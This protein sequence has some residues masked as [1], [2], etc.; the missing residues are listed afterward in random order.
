MNQHALVLAANSA[1]TVSYWSQGKR[2]VRYF[3]G[4]NKLFQLSNDHPVGLMIF[5]TATLHEVPWELV[6]K[7]FREQL[8]GASSDK[9]AGYTQKFCDFVKGHTG[10]FPAEVRRE[11]L[12]SYAMLAAWMH[13]NTW[14]KS[15]ELTGTPPEQK[16]AA[17]RQQA[18]NL[19]DQSRTWTA[20]EP[21]TP[22]DI[23]GAVAAHRDEVKT[24]IAAKP[25]EVALTEADLAAHPDL[26]EMMAEIALRSVL[27]KYDQYLNSTGIVIGGYGD[28]EFF[29]SFEVLECYGFLDQHFVTKRSDKSRSVA[30]DVPAAIEPFATTSMINTFRMGIGQDVFAS[31]LAATERT[32]ADF[33]AELIALV[34]PG[35]NVPDLTE[36]IARFVQSH[37][38]DWFGQTWDDHYHPLARV[39]SS[40]PVTDM[41]ALAKS[42]IEL[43]SLKERVTRPTE[44]VGGPIDVAVISKHDGFVWIERK[45]YFRADL[46][47]RFFHRQHSH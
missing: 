35:T 36:R 29:P 19:L 2:E 9:L 32:L 23:E 43:Q 30:R 22:E 24:R 38:N 42:L 46:N 18:Q 39:I 20:T 37:Q 21:L 26:A 41:A 10:L 31:V 44:S 15:T 45:H 47:P 16:P 27:C 4:A 11:A 13:V 5:G 28:E 33:A 1:T 8:G 7:E 25:N 14:Q 34:A 17:L 12:L 40:L 3:K 6:V